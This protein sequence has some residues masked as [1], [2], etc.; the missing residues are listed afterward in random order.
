[1]KNRTIIFTI[2]IGMAVSLIAIFFSYNQRHLPN[3]E[4][5]KQ[6]E[7]TPPRNRGN[8]IQIPEEKLITAAVNHLKILPDDSLQLRHPHYLVNYAE[9]GITFS[10]RQSSGAWR[11]N[12]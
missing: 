4:P 3:T 9:E 11:W 2:F 10:P 1:M 6:G 7:I 5:I 8:F 12:L